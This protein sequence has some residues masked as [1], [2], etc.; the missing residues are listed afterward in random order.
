MT[1]IK[2]I[3]RIKQITDSIVWTDERAEGLGSAYDLY[4]NESEPLIR[5]SV[6]SF[7]KVIPLE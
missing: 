3:K 1:R 2:R 6:L 4:T 7:Q 5:R